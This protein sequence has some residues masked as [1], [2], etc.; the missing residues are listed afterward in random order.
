MYGKRF[1]IQNE[2]NSENEAKY[3][4]KTNEEIRDRNWDAK[5]EKEVMYIGMKRKSN[6]KIR[7]DVLLKQINVNKLQTNYRKAP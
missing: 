2:I 3:K 4:I 6:S 5:T 1:N 7:D